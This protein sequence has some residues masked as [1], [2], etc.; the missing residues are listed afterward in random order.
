MMK[1]TRKLVLRRQTVRVLAPI[2]LA[3][4]VGGADSVDVQCAALAD[5]GA[6]AC[7]TGTTLA[8]IATAA[9]G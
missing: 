8:A 4:V 1:T 2:D 9:C 3:R 5:S 7:S 6:K